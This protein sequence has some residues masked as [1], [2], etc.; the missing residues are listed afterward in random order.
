MNRPYLIAAVVGVVVAAGLAA[1]I[2]FALVETGPEPA[3]IAEPAT[4]AEPPRVAAAP[5]EQ[6][7]PAPIPAPTAPPAP[8][9]AASA[10]EPKA[11]AGPAEG[12]KPAPSAEAPKPAETVIAAKAPEAQ[13][14]T[15]PKIPPPTFDVVRIEPDGGAVIAGRAEP[16]AEVTVLEGSNVL[17]SP[18]ANRRGEWVLVPEKPLAPGS[19][20]LSLRA[21]T[22]DGGTVESADVVVVVVP[23]KKPAE[24]AAAP[25]PASP[26]AVQVAR[27]GTG[28]S[29]VLQRPETAE[30][31]PAAAEG[32]EEALGVDT[33]DYDDR[34]N[35]ALSG[36]AKPG[37]QVRVYVDNALLGE[38]RADKSGRWTLSP[39]VDV[40]PG[41]H[42][43]R[44]D[45]IGEAGKVVARVEVPFS[46]ARPL[47]DVPGHLYVVVQPGNSLWRIA[48]RTY[49]RGLQ[50]TVIYEANA[51]LITDPNLIYP[52]QIFNVPSVN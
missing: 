10:V 20:E 49:G 48:R 52:G 24:V 21:R 42:R 4:K 29:R 27:E 18:R 3:P 19:R 34:G 38:E 31:P 12:L 41:L 5:A 23:E 28:P 11:D 13:P 16:G 17:G 35:V 33:V 39:R 7:R 2:F 47:P 46:R 37:A 36:E 30:A 1:G 43:L 40:E 14:A 32:K 50:Y 6:P 9:P 45:E 51:N 22:K 25:Q 44:V 15:A 26:L 8:A